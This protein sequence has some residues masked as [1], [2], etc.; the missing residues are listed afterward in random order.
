MTKATDKQ[1]AA[2]FQLALAELAGL[3]PSKVV[4]GSVN[5]SIERAAGGTVARLTAE[6]AVEVDPDEVIRLAMQHNRLTAV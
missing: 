3:D 6:V 1:D 4:A 5:V 2:L